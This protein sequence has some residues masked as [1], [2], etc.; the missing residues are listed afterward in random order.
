MTRA[1]PRSGDLRRAGRALVKEAVWLLTSHEPGEK[2]DV[3]LFAARRGGS[4][5]LMQVIGAA[6]GFRTLDQPFSVMTANLTPGHYRKIPKYPYGEIVAPA[7]DEF[8]ELRPYVESLLAGQLPVNAP[9]RFWASGFRWRTNRQLLKIV[10]AKSIAGWLDDE[11]DLDV[12]VLTRHPITQSLSCLRNGWTLTARAFLDNPRFVERWLGGG[13]EGRCHDIFEGGSELDRFVLN[14]ALENVA[15]L[16][17]APSRPW[18]VTSYEATVLEP[19]SVLEQLDSYLGLGGVEPL[20]QAVQRPSRSSRLSTGERIEAMRSGDSGVLLKRP[21]E[22]I[23]VEARVRAM[24][25]VEELGIDLY[26]ATEIGP[27]RT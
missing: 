26:N 3:A 20:R 9:Y 2:N 22:S 19:D 12:V 18:L 4:T 24:R 10:G 13:L 5:W 23:E 27:R 8:D 14:W 15:I 25:I 16:H 11:F 7:P 21:L 17:E 6:E 1:E